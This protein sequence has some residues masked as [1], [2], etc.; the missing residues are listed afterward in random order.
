M[1]TR[2]RHV[3]RLLLCSGLVPG[4]AHRASCM[5]CKFPT[6]ELHPHELGLWN[7]WRLEKRR[8]GRKLLR[9]VCFGK[10][11]RD[12]GTAVLTFSSGTCHVTC[13]YTSLL[14][15]HWYPCLRWRFWALLSCAM[16]STPSSYSDKHDIWVCLL[17]KSL[18]A[19]S[20]FL[21]K[22]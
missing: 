13:A 21:R 11:P 19:R 15:P 7:L 8:K 3:L 6:T 22:S 16:A 4:I 2:E 14:S 18:S 5:L 10:W 1:P 12:Q 17:W 20:D 9:A